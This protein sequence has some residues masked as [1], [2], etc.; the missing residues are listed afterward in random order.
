M[1]SMNHEYVNWIVS[2]RSNSD[3]PID[4]SVKEI[5]KRPNLSNLR[6]ALIGEF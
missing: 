3:R 2:P 4:D 6:A 5:D 1:L